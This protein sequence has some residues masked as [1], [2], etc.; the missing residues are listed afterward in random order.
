MKQNRIM[1]IISANNPNKSLIDYTRD[2]SLNDIDLIVVDDGSDAKYSE[3]FDK[4]VSEG[5]LVLRHAKKMG[6]G[7][8][9][10]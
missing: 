1:L 10:K 3:L 4:I 7:R 6:H 5:H 2:L 8:S 9:L